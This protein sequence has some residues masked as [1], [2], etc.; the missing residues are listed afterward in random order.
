MG[1][2]RPERQKTMEAWIESEGTLTA[3]A[4]AEQFGVSENLVR[5]WK[6]QDK[7]ILKLKKPRGAPKGNQNAKG[8]GAPKGNSNGKGGT[9]GNKNAQTHGAYAQPDMTV[10]SEDELEEVQ[11]AYALD[12]ALGELTARRIDLM[13]K[14]Q[15]LEENPEEK[16][17]TGG[18]DVVKKNS[19]QGSMVYWESK[20]SRLEKLEVQYNRVLKN[21]LKI[22]E[23]M[24]KDSREK[25]R[26]EIERERLE[27]SRQKAMGVFPEPEEE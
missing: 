25:M 14:I 6:S 3:K 17:D 20:F 19:R 8:H 9:P 11:E 22:H 2:A 10:F 18:I 15:A 24:Q 12:G 16:Y 5:K 1:K 26:I 23:E 4:L 13:K 7:W 21:I 27:L